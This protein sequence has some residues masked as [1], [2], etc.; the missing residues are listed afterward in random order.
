M[1]KY[2]L[3][4]AQTHR[5]HVCCW[6]CCLWN[7]CP[8]PRCPRFYTLQWPWRRNQKSPAFWYFR[9]K[10]WHVL[11]C[12]CYPRKMEISQGIFLNKITS[13][14][15]QNIFGNMP[16]NDQSI[17]YFKLILSEFFAIFGVLHL[18][19]RFL[20]SHFFH[21]ILV[22]ACKALWPAVNEHRIAIV[23][24]KIL[25]WLR[26]LEVSLHDWTTTYHRS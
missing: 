19:P 1:Q 7:W 8:L 23:Y 21:K 14:F 26:K 16:L 4:S 2:S 5:F 24:F 3:I 10:N 22:I 18:R 17:K 12:Y 11:T 9:S 13:Y 6:W 20:S 25:R 15:S